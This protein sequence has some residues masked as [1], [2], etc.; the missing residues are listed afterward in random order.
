MGRFETQSS[1]FLKNGRYRRLA[2]RRI[3]RLK[4]LRYDG[5]CALGWICGRRESALGYAS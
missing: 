2:F 5:S 4:F 3:I 1:A